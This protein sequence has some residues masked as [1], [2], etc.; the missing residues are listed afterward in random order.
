M[1][2]KIYLCTVVC[3]LYL[4]WNT[5]FKCCV[6]LWHFVENRL[7]IHSAYLVDPLVRMIVEGPSSV[8]TQPLRVFSLTLRQ[9]Y[10]LYDADCSVINYNKR[11]ETTQ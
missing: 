5:N 2:V 10:L 7:D 1:V 4:L 3:I 8:T 9:C 11:L 6:L